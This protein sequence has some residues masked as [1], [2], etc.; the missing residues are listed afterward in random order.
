MYLSRLSPLKNVR[1]NQDNE[2]FMPIGSVIQS[3]R[4]F[5]S[6]ISISFIKGTQMDGK[7]NCSASAIA[8]LP[9]NSLELSQ[10]EVRRQD[11]CYIA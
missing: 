1:K 2:E 3:Y 11:L 7:L 5:Q 8:D 4:N 9:K 6:L 10:V